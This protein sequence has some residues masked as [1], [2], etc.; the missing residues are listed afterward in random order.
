[1][2]GR[3]SLSFPL[4]L[5]DM[6]ARLPLWLTVCNLA[7]PVKLQGLLSSK[8]HL[9]SIQKHLT[10]SNQASCSGR[11]GEDWS[12]SGLFCFPKHIKFDLCIVTN[13]LGSFLPGFE[14]ISDTF[15]LY[16]ATFFQN[17]LGF[18]IPPDFKYYLQGK[19]KTRR[20]WHLVSHFLPRA[21]FYRLVGQI[22][23]LSLPVYSSLI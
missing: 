8:L 23:P 16:F 10:L 22:Y 6:A 12:S 13:L 3:N 18:S 20:H 11:N 14:M 19:W 9:M 15:K 2:T 5:L 4:L 17:N 1:M 7:H 21:D